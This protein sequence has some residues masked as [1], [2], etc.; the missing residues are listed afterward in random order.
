MGALFYGTVT[1]G[2]SCTVT[3]TSSAGQFSTVGV[4]LGLLS[5]LSSTTPGTGCTGIFAPG[6]GTTY[7]CSSGITVSSGGFGIAA[8]GYGSVTAM[9]SSN[10]TIDSQ[11]SFGTGGGVGSVGIAHFTTSETPQFGPSGFNQA[12]ITSAPWS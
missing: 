7:N 4:A 6:T 3:V 2:A 8:V 9:T 11:T 5:N 10:M 1:G 12:L